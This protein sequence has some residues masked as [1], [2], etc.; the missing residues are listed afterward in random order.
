MTKVL[1]A[2]DAAERLH[3]TTRTVRR[4]LRDGRIPGRKV[5]KAWL[6]PEAALTKFLRGP[7]VEEK[8]SEA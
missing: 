6:I 7:V 2:E 4:W 1:T 8:S 5:G 3:T